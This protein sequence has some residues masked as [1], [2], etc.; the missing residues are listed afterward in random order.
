[1][2]DHAV[3]R[4]WSSDCF[5]FL[6]HR[7]ENC[8]ANR[9]IISAAGNV[10]HDDMVASAQKMFAELQPVPPK[11]VP[12]KPYFVGAKLEYRNDE[13]G[14]YVMFNL[15]WP[16]VP[17]KSPDAPAFLVMQEIMGSYTKF[18]PKHLIHAHYSH[19]TLIRQAGLRQQY[20]CIDYYEVQQLFYRDTG[21]FSVYAVC[22]EGAA[23]HARAELQFYVN[24]F[25][26]VITDEEVNRGKQALK[27]KLGQ[28]KSGTAD[29]ADTL[30]TNLY[31]LGRHVSTEELVKR[32]NCI[33]SEDIKR[34]AYTHLHDSEISVTCFGPTSQL[35]NYVNIRLDN[36]IRRY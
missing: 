31:H 8:S 19:N 2:I 32:I 1:M 23:E 34:V 28:L 30:A 35:P 22:E 27:M 14:P 25:S 9:L 4:Y 18:D 29:R 16:S 3:A 12:H 7:E 36:S 6:L 21:V 20:G 26:Y 17:M 33:D 13:V 24:K 5:F 15:S 11:I 10:E